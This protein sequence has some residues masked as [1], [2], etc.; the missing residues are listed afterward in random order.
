[1]TNFK[2]IQ[3]GTVVNLEF[4]VI[5]K[6]IQRLFELGYEDMIKEQLKAK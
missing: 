5:G 1:V 4:D 6:Y 2:G 3:K